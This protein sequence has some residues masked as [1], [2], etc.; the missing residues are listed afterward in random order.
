MVTHFNEISISLVNKKKGEIK[1][2]L[3]RIDAKEIVPEPSVCFCPIREKQKRLGE[4]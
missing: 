1:G 3:R 4:R 2:T